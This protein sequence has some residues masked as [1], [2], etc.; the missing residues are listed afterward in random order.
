MITLIT[1]I[2]IYVI[3]AFLGICKEM[4]KFVFMLLVAPVYLLFHKVDYES[5]RWKMARLLEE[6]NNKLR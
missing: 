3:L 6:I 4:I 5:P 1:I 2:G